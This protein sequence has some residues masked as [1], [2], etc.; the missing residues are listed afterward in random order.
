LIDTNKEYKYISLSAS[1]AA[2]ARKKRMDY[3]MH[4]KKPDRVPVAPA[5]VHYYATKAVGV[6]NKDAMYRPEDIIKS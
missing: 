2:P 5:V 3:A 1:P 4:L 6:S